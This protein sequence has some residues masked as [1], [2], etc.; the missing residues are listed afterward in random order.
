M[1]CHFTTAIVQASPKRRWSVPSKSA[2][3]WWPC[4][5]SEDDGNVRRGLPGWFKATVPEK[6]PFCFS[7]SR[8]DASQEFGQILTVCGWSLTVPGVSGVTGSALHETSFI[9]RSLAALADVLGALS[10]RRGHIP[11]RKSKLATCCRTRSVRSVP[12]KS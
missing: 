12:W 1:D 3:C 10:E 4:S 8:R 7:E 11:S 6:S 2:S 9:N 5:L